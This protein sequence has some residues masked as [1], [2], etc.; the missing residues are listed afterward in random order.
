MFSHLSERRE[1]TLIKESHVFGWCNPWAAVR[2]Y[3]NFFWFGPANIQFTLSIV[4]CG[5]RS[6]E[7]GNDFGNNGEQRRFFSFSSCHLC[8]AREAVG[9]IFINNTPNVLSVLCEWRLET[10]VVW[11]QITVI[12]ISRL[13]IP[14]PFTWIRRRNLVAGVILCAE[15]ANMLL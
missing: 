15:T 13:G 3:G 7:N 9:I 12:D 4:S 14:G 5:E 2:D 8:N 6:S 11:S 10:L 1:N